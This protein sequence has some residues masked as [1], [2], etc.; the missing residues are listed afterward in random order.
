MHYCYYCNY[1]NYKYYNYYCYY[2]YNYNL[3]VVHLWWITVCGSDIWHRAKE[4]LAFLHY[5]PSSFQR[6]SDK[7]NVTLHSS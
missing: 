6:Y 4:A 3:L 2:Y 1:Y 7:P 5:K